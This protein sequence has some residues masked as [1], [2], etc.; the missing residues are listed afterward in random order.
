MVAN[1]ATYNWISIKSHSIRRSYVY[2]ILYKKKWNLMYINKN[3]NP[4]YLFLYDNSM[5]YFSYIG[6]W[7]LY[8]TIN[9]NINKYEIT[10]WSTDY[11][12]YKCT[13]NLKFPNSHN[14]L[15][16]LFI[17]ALLYLN[18]LYNTLYI[19]HIYKQYSLILIRKLFLWF[20]ISHIL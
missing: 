3:Y 13:T 2:L 8:I 16:L 20:A 18:R 4:T 14:I 11:N 17:D 15:S 6:I 19:S 12:V 10:V 9:V 5:I 7:N 1:K